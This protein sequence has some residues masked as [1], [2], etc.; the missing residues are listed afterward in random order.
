MPLPSQRYFI[1]AK[2]GNGMKDRIKE[3]MGWEECGFFMAII[4]LLFW[5]YER[6]KFKRRTGMEITTA[7]TSTDDLI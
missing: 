2:G 1:Q 6:W 7:T 5:K 3:I 4:F